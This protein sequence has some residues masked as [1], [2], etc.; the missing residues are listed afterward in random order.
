MTVT[1]PVRYPGSLLAERVL[2]P[3]GRL[4]KVIGFYNRGQDES[5]LVLFSSGLTHEYT[6]DDLKAE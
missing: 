2:V 3:D 6:A 4:G 1:S 5:V